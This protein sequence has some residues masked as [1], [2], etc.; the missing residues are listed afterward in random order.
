M[1][2]TQSST[3]NPSTPQ[4]DP[5]D[6]Y[7]TPTPFTHYL[8]ARVRITGRVCAPCHGDGAIRAAAKT[9][10][11]DYTREWVTND[12]DRRWHCD[13]NLNAASAMLW[14]AIG[15]VDWTVDNPPFNDWLDIAEHAL[16][17]SH[18]GVALHLRASVHEILKTG[19]RRQWMAE[20]LPTG[21]LWLPR[22]EYQ[23]SPK[24]GK[25]SRDSCCA[26]WVIWYRNPHPQ[27]IDY[28]PEWVIKKLDE[29]AARRRRSIDDMQR[30]RG[31]R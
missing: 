2:A 1:S 19:P 31:R 3:A 26:C 6:W 25:W 8:F 24:T 9:S 17:H 28:A 5:F 23:R 10:G 16:A 15:F 21:I 30:R 4:R 12:L 22:C 11:H 13:Y 27:F 14:N 29:D 20:H 18:I 7:P